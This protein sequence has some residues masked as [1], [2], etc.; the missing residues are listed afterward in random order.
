MPVTLFLSQLDI[1]VPYA[2]GSRLSEAMIWAVKLIGVG[3]QG[4]SF[5]RY[6]W[7]YSGGLIAHGIK[8]DD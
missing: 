7:P 1:A 2:C 8:A 5:G 6:I 4:A 3:L